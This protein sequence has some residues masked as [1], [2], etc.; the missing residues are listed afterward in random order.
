MSS[1]AQERGFQFPSWRAFGRDAGEQAHVDALT[2]ELHASHAREETLMR[3]MRAL[4][5]RQ[6]MLAQEFEHRLVNGLQ[7][8]ASL[9]SLQSRNASTPEA[10]DQLTVAA[11]RVAALGRVHHRLHLLDHQNHVEFK[12]YLRHLCGDL[13]NL[14]F[15][16]K[17]G[18]RIV[19]EGAKA[20]L[21]TAFAI[22]LGFIVNELVTNAAK[23]ARGDINVRFETTARDGHILLVMDDGPGLPAEFDPAS[24]K[25][26]G[27]RIVRALVKQIDGEL[28][29][30]PREH[31]RGARFAIVF[32][33]PKRGVNGA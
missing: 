15:E 7:L 24:S 4:S 21:P 1:A 16:E 3:E 2:A 33:S 25:G 9:L 26:L 10:S 6:D 11:R 22:P 14:L 28:R 23:F 30:L 27:M 17:A 29:V 20:E 31:G 5:Q 8:I 12:D 13:S 19:V 18:P 32:Q